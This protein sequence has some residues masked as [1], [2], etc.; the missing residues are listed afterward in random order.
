LPRQVTYCEPLSVRISST[1][2]RIWSFEPE[3][4]PGRPCPEQRVSPRDGLQAREH[5][6]IGSHGLDSVAFRLTGARGGRERVSDQVP[7]VKRELSCTLGPDVDD[8]RAVGVELPEHFVGAL[9]RN[10]G[11]TRRQRPRTGK[12]RS[13]FTR[14]PSPSRRRRL[15][16]HTE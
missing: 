2:L 13:S 3:R 14:G 12:D 5:E 1:S 11:L 4:H 15:S 7:R 9:G 6:V 10:K 16:S 8:Q